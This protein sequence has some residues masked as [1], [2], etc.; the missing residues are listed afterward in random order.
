[1]AAD[2]QVGRVKPSFQEKRRARAVES[3]RNAAET[4]GPVYPGMALFAVTR[5]QFSMIDALLHCLACVGPARISIWTW[6][7]AEFEVQCVERLMLERG[8]TAGLLVIDGAARK[9]NA[10]IIAHWK[11]TF[12]PESVRF[13]VNHAKVATI[14]G[15]GL[16]LLLRGS[17]NLNY[18][19]RFENFDLS[20]GCPGFDLVRRLEAELPLLADDA[21]VPE[22]W[23]S[24]KLHEAYTP[25]QLVPFGGVKTWAK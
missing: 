11:R 17:L 7:V 4:I 19:P 9:K 2:E 20:E 18:N 6:T 12:G 23:A 5:G 25:E 8:I 16:R 22:T 14:E 24:A 1:M 15:G 13:T 3:F 21:T 10:E